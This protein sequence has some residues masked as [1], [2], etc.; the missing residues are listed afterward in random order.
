MLHL[1]F[2]ILLKDTRIF[3]LNLLPFCSSSRRVFKWNGYSRCRAC[4]AEWNPF[5]GK[6]T[7]TANPIMPV[8][9][10]FVT[11]TVLGLSASCFSSILTLCISLWLIMKNQR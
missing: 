9:H 8:V 7:I 5:Q 11:I 2:M 4:L 10:F 1:L 3:F 6:K